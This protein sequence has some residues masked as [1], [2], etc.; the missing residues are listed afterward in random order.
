LKRTCGRFRSLTLLDIPYY[1]ASVYGS[2]LACAV[3][4]DGLVPKS[5]DADM[6]TVTASFFMMSSTFPPPLSGEDCH[7]PAVRLN[8]SFSRNFVSHI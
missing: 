8:S 2:F 7:L 5:F 3:D 6:L 4:A 1:Q